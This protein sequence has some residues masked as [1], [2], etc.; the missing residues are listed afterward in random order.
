MSLETVD[1]ADAATERALFIPLDHKLPKVLVNTRRL[2]ELMQ[3]RVLVS[4]DSWPANSLYPIG[5]FV[6]SFGAVGV[7]SVE[8]SV[9][10]HE[11]EVP[12]ESFSPAVMACLPPTDWKITEDLIGA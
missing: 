2:Q 3:C 5:H 9:L 10:L 11:F 12:Y 7:K 6:R 4:V 8:T 1:T